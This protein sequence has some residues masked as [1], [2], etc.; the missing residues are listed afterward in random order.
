[1]G[2]GTLSLARWHSR[3]EPGAG[4]VGV[5]MSRVRRALARRRRRRP[6][7]P[8]PPA[9]TTTPA[10]LHLFLTRAT[11]ASSKLYQGLL[12]VHELTTPSTTID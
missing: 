9:V 10:G 8:Q 12:Y 11:V 5:E 7:Q 2:S 1:M 4:L 3:G 6:T